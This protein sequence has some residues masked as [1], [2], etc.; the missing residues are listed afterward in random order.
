VTES[1]YQH[2]QTIPSTILR[3]DAAPRTNGASERPAVSGRY[4]WRALLGEGGMGRVDRVHDRD[5]LRDVAAKH[6]LPQLRA[7]RTQ[8]AQ[9]LWEARVTAYLDH[10]NIVPVHDIGIAPDGHLYFTMKYVSGSTLQAALARRDAEFTLPR[11]LRLF[12]QIC[13]AVAFAHARGVLHRDLKPANV[14]LGEFGEVLVGDWGLAMPLPNGEDALRA[15][16]PEGLSIESAGTPS[17]MSPEQAKIDTLDVRSDIYTLGVIL[18]ELVALRRAYDGDT[19]ANVLEKVKSGEHAPLSEIAPT[20]PAT[21]IA[22][23]EKAMSL[24]PR[25]RYANVNALADDVETALDGRTPTA[26]DASLLTQAVR[27][28]FGR[29]PAVAQLR[30]IDLDLWV[31]GAGSAGA[32]GAAYFASRVAPYWWELI[33]LGALLALSPT[34]RYYRARRRRVSSRR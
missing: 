13:N 18:Y 26:D 25:D 16:M 11:R 4:E 28:Y 33:V 6:M 32:G 22:I 10:P 17:Y 34:I 27:Y 30:T 24:D 23:V 29:D 7:D 5:L 2:L 12:L 3:V 8:L 15:A 19:A 14:L 31:L 20:A 9:F 1:A 21:V